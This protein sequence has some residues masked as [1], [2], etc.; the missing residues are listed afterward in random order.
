MFLF[1]IMFFVDLI[2]KSKLE[3]PFN[4]STRYEDFS[5]FIIVDQ[6]YTYCLGIC[7]IFFPFRIYQWLAH[8][9]MFFSA[10]IIINTIGRTAPGVAVYYILV[11]IMV[12][13]FACGFRVMLGQ[14][15]EEF[16]TYG[17]CVQMILIGNFSLLR[18]KNI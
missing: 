13:I 12:L 3:V 4:D 8:A 16:S 6:I 14:S 15:Y 5:K 1:V 17:G 11:L 18:A 7:C 2:L 9:P 10:K